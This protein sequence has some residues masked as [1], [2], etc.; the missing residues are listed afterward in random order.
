MARRKT[1]SSVSEKPVASRHVKGVFLPVPTKPR[2]ANG[3][4]TQPGTVTVPSATGTDRE[5]L[6]SIVEN[7]D[8]AIISKRLDGV[9]LSWNNAA[10]RLFGY[11]ADE[12]VGQPIFRLIPPER[13]QEEQEIL[14]RLR[15]GERIDHYETVRCAKDGRRLEVSVSISPLRDASGRIIGACKIAR[16]IS[17]RKRVQD[18]LRKSEQLMRAILDTAADAI[19]TIDERGIIQSANPA[20]GRLF[21]YESAELV[22]ENV[23][24][25][26]PDPFRQEHDGYLRNYG[27]TGMAKIIGIGREVIGLRKDGVTF[28]MHLSVGEVQLGKRLFTGIVHDLSGRRQLEEQ[29]INAA[30]GEQRRIGQD[31]H[32]GLCQDLVG[33]AFSID[34]IIPGLS[35]RAVDTI[36]ALR[37]VSASVRAAAGQARDLSHGLN[38][39]DVRVGGLPAALENLCSKVSES[40]GVQCAFRWDQRADFPNNTFANHLYRMCQEAISN[41]IKHGKANRIQVSLDKHGKTVAISISDNGMGMPQLALEGI[42][43]GIVPKGQASS[44][45]DGTG[46]GLQT[47]RYRAQVIGGSF[48]V[49]P[50]KGGGTVV[51][52]V[53]SRHPPIADNH[54]NAAG[55]SRNAVRRK[56]ARSR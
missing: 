30:A 40:F 48:A 27:R 36:N 3:V 11:H 32:D 13:L 53:I 1:L 26:M 31:L 49:R 55:A 34:A 22:G 46:I 42:N 51:S 52:C 47:M 45:S 54:R 14:R 4:N 29:I 35:D 6:A 25:L 50:R 38:P 39:V 33:I 7:S 41:A 5:I 12:I 16:D 43:N 9:I 10:A 17:E 8:D 20:T 18:D 44:S 23:K 15:C 24:L 37:T 21:G 19:I 56:R 2:S 28:P